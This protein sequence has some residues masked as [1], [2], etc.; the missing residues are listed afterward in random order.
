MREYYHLLE[1]NTSYFSH[2]ILW[3][4]LLFVLSIGLW[5][6]H[7]TLD[8]VTRGLG[9]VIPSRHVQVVQNL[10]GGIVSEILVR[11]GEIV[12]EGQILLR[13]DDTRFASS[14]RESQ[15]QSVALRAKIARLSAE[16]ESQL[17]KL[18]KKLSAEEQPLFDNELALARSR[19]DQVQAGVTILEQ[20]KQQKLQEIEELKSRQ[21]QL[22]GSYQLALRELKITEP[23]VEKGVISEVELLRLQR[24][25]SK[26]RGDLEATQLAMPRV[27]A[28]IQEVD[29]KIEE[30]KVNFRTQALAELNQIKTE[31]SRLS[32]SH[33]ALKD[34]VTRT[35]VRSPVKG[36]IKQLKI[37]T[38][39]GVV[40][41][42]MDLVEIVPLE[43]SLLVE[44]Q[45]RP[46]DIAFLHPG[47]TV[48]VKLTAYDFSIF[49][50][51]KASL[52]QISADTLVNEQG[53]PVF[54]I[55]VRT[56][57]NYLG[58]EQ[59][60]LPIIPGMTA[61]VDILTGKKTV[62]DYLLKPIK[63]VQQHALR[64]R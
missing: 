6:H 22:Q 21:L 29:R 30:L 9:K 13:I 34:R 57:R 48:R 10:E 47:Q 32:E 59:V 56:E 16:A 20:Q 14:Y 46:S 5:A 41:P 24:E 27:E 55:K 4:T 11:E 23:L 52:V 61:T 1:E 26:L 31:L 60:P 25:I 39:G 18:P 45:I 35:A 40:Q 12:Q 36:T 15:V 50:S 8:E 49:G 7:A 53:E 54:L 42:G 37:T 3:S 64:E 43:D 63:K 44:A 19:Q 58:S 62:L 2:L 17:F 28:A 33:L 51:L 38:I